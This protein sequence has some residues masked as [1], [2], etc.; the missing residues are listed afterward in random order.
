MLAKNYL[1]FEVQR[2]NYV[3]FLLKV[4]DQSKF[5]YS[6]KNSSNF[7]N[8]QVGKNMHFTT[9]LQGLPNI[10]LFGCTC[11]QL[12]CKE[13]TCCAQVRNQLTLFMQQKLAVTNGKMP[14]RRL[15]YAYER[16]MQS[17]AL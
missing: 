13:Q 7:N 1:P 11:A 3:T 17:Q 9:E 6:T 14:K 12:D 5:K 16:G 8:K 10:T 4:V 15:V 2:G